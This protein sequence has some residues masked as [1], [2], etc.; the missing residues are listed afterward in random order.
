MTTKIEAGHRLTAANSGHEQVLHRAI[1]AALRDL[2][3][4][5]EVIDITQTPQE[6]QQ[7]LALLAKLD[8]A[9]MQKS[10]M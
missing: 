6:F 1:E 10:R 7:A 2:K 9:Y 5:G 3:A 8:H 4:L